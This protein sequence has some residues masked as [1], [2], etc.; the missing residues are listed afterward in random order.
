M[1]TLAPPKRTSTMV[2][3]IETERVRDM[4]AMGEAVPGQEFGQ[5]WQESSAFSS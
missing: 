5:F 4:W 1:L 2:A 3:V